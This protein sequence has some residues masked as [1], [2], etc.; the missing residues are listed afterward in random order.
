MDGSNPSSDLG[1]GITRDLLDRLKRPLL[2]KIGNIGGLPQN[3]PNGMPVIDI[4]FV[5]VQIKKRKQVFKESTVSIRVVPANRMIFDLFHLKEEGEVWVRTAELI[6]F[7]VKTQIRTGGTL[8]S[9]LDFVFG[10]SNKA[11]EVVFD[12]DAHKITKRIIL[13]KNIAL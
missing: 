11:G 4:D 6:N 1:F 7:L 3:L 12:L 13:I 10:D 5:T 8:R 2:F 9:S